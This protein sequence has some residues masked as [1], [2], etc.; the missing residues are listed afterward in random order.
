MILGNPPYSGHS[1]NTGEWIRGLIEDYKKVDGNPLGEKNPKWLQ[2]D[3][4]KFLRFAQWKIEQAGRGIVGLITN[5]SYLDNPT[6]RGMRRSLMH[7]FDDIYILDLHGNA[8]KRETCPDGSLDK[9]VFDIRQGVAI[10][11][12]VKRG[13]S[14]MDGQDEQ[15]GPK[16]LVHHGDCYGTRESKYSLLNNHDLGSTQWDRLN[17]TSPSYLFVPR[18]AALEDGYRRFISVPEVFPVSSVGV[19][20]ARDRLTIQWSSEEVWSTVIPFSGMDPELARQCYQ[21]GKDARDWNVTQAQ[22]DLLDSGPI[23]E[24]IVPILYRPFDVRHT[25]YTGRS[26]GFIC[27]PR[28]EVMNHMLTGD[29][30]ALMIP[31]QHKNEFGALA[32]KFI[33]AHKSVAAYDINYHFPLYIYPTAEPINLFSNHQT[34]E[35]KPN[36]N[37]KLVEVLTEAHGQE[38]SVEAIFHYV[39]AM[40]YVPAYRIKYAEFLRT[41]FPRIPFTVDR[42]LFE[43]FANIGARLANLHLLSSPE[44]DPPVCR[45]EGEGD[46]VIATSKSKG[47]LYDADEQRMYINGTQYF[48]TISSAVYE[49]RIGGYQVCDKWLKDRKE[50]RL[51]L[52]DIRTYCRMVTALAKTLEIQQAIDDLYNDVEDNCVTFETS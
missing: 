13:D 11:F 52:D 32:T 30:L 18:D 37:P 38:P 2:D 5:H 39:Y 51:D 8:L 34:S 47:L 12:F 28:S 40:L 6:F 14:D 35:V 1:S 26:R 9:N 4:V 22:K 44:L 41:D 43:R 10:A 29:N 7:T 3:Y 33:S 25:Y 15:D 31:K 24:K 45:F 20:T 21:L 50:R 42:D 36:L 23:R 48:D 16:A 49:Y 17:P 46:S 19:V 27:R